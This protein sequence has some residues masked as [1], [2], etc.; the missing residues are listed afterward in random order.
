MHDEKIND[1]VLQKGI[2]NQ[3]YVVYTKMGPFA[4]PKTCYKGH[5]TYETRDMTCVES[6]MS[7]FFLLL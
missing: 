7:Q 5:V 3:K 4:Q 1:V 2:E 6:S